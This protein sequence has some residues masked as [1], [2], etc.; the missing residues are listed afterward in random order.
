ML[1]PQQDAR[2]FFRLHKTLLLFANQ[3]LGVC[4]GALASLE[5]FNPARLEET[6][7]LRD[8]LLERG[9][10]LE[11]FLQENPAHLSDEELAI[12]SLWRHRV[13]GKFCVFRQMKKHTILCST[14]SPFV[15]YGVT[16]LTEPFDE[17]VGG[18]MPVLI[19]TVLLPYRDKIIYDGLLRVYNVWF[20]PGFRRHLNEDYQVAKKLFGIVTSLPV[21]APPYRGDTVTSNGKLRR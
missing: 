8:A 18:R 6:A 19:E 15:A 12:V 3:H 10:I 2:L 13:A 9:D 4:S 20:G 14:T 11:S 1:L 7:R 17:I 16:A 21:S 5:D